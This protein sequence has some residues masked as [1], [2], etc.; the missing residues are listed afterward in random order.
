MALHTKE[1]EARIKVFLEE[2]KEDLKMNDLPLVENSSLLPVLAPM[3]PDFVPFA[4][5]TSQHCVP[6]K[7]LLRKVYHPYKDPVG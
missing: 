3:F 1:L 5:S 2:A 6:P 7:S 4:I